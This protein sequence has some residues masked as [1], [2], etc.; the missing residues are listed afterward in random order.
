MEPSQYS[1]LPP[2]FSGPGIGFASNGGTKRYLIE[3]ESTTGFTAWR[4][5]D[6]T[7][8]INPAETVDLPASPSVAFWP[9]V[10][11]QD[12]TPGGEIVSLDCHANELTN[13]DVGRH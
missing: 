5:D 11:Y 9:C 4:L 10:G 12:S 13:I 3:A 7:I 2:A 6:G 8:L 1:P